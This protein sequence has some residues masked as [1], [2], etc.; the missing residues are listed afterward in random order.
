MSS[1]LV[2]EYL[3]K[4]TNT[5]WKHQTLTKYLLLFYF[6]PINYSWF[7]FY[8]EQGVIYYPKYYLSNYGLL[9]AGQKHWLSPIYFFL[10]SLNTFIWPAKFVP[11]WHFKDS[12]ISSRNLET[13]QIYICILSQS[14]TICHKIDAAPHFCQHYDSYPWY[15]ILL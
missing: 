5:V 3:K 15:Q 1:F 10:V 8:T 12:I 11:W 4:Y 7:Q 14:V 6:I 2:H 9:H 13:K